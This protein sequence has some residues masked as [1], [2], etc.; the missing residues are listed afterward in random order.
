MRDISQTAGSN[1]RDDSIDGELLYDFT[2]NGN[3]E[4]LTALIA[5]YTALV[6]MRSKR[7][8]VSTLDDEDLFQEGMIALLSAIR[9][10]RP[11]NG[12]S[13]KTF[14]SVCVN[15]KMRNVL[16]S[17]MR[18]HN[19]AGFKDIGDLVGTDEAISDPAQ[20]LI[21]KEDAVRRSKRIETLLTEFELSVLRRYLSGLS[22]TKIA[23]SLEASSK[24]V[25]N[26]L[27]RIRKKLRA[28]FM[29]S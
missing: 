7:Y 16:S 24:S 18:R 29:S 19:A 5:R 8:A 28:S 25:D 14:A 15:N 11:E 12:A 1:G 17:H 3:Y 10:Y 20:V 4:A 9:H 2:V 26:A 6:R 23:S 21:S 27:Q 22:Y 13:F